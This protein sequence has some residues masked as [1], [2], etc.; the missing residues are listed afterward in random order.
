MNAFKSLEN[1]EEIN[2]NVSEDLELERFKT[3]QIMVHS[4]LQVLKCTSQKKRISTLLEIREGWKKT[5][6]Q[7]WRGKWCMGGC[8]V[9]PFAC[10]SSGCYHLIRSTGSIPGQGA[11][12][13][14]AQG[15]G[16]LFP[17]D[18]EGRHHPGLGV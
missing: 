16:W 15:W 10:F 5:V 1:K 12:P 4:D 11:G 6:K 9:Q 3:A 13:R 17:G 18:G 14:A 2:K 7:G 8:R